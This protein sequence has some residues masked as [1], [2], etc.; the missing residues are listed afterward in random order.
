MRL[1]SYMLTVKHQGKNTHNYVN[2]HIWCR[3]T[4][5]RVECKSND[6]ILAFGRFHRPKV[7]ARG[8]IRVYAA[9]HDSS[10][11]QGRSRRL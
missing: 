8:Q 9:A 4:F 5:A 11:L 1:P 7:K 3:R 2:W 6:G 10:S